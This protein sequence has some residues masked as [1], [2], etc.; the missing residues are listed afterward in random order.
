MIICYLSFLVP[1][2][3]PNMLWHTCILKCHCIKD[4]FETNFV[5]HL[6]TCNEIS[7]LF[8]SVHFLTVLLRSSV[9]LFSAKQ[10]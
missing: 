1:S 10:G 7:K 2:K 4:N 3:D 9:R 5:K 6:G 8:S